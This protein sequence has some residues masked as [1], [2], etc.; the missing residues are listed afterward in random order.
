MHEHLAVLERHRFGR[1]ETL[2]RWRLYDEDAVSALHARFR[3]HVRNTDMNR[4]LEYATPRYQIAPGKKRENVAA[5][6]EL[7]PPDEAA[8]RRA[9]LLP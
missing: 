9:I 7:L 6:L 4:F 8:E 1:I 2:P 3:D 5:L